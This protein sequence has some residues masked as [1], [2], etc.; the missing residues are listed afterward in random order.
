MIRAIFFYLLLLAVVKPA[1][2]QLNSYDSI[3]V[4]SDWRTFRVHLPKGYTGSKFY[5]LLLGL[6]G[7]GGS[8]LQFALSSELSTKADSA[9]FIVVYPDGKKNPFHLCIHPRSIASFRSGQPLMN[10]RL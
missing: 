10:V 9:G 4:K 1:Y 3:L 2:S 8:S 7:G 5:P 6:H